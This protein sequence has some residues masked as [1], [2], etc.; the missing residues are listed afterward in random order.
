MDR[1]FEERVPRDGRARNLRR[2]IAS[3]SRA[4]ALIALATTTLATSGALAQGRW[5][6]IGSGTVERILAYDDPETWQELPPFAFGTYPA[7]NLMWLELL[8]LACDRLP[9]PALCDPEVF[10]VAYDASLDAGSCPCSG[11]LLQEI[12]V[13]IHYDADVV[14]ALGARESDLRLVV[15]E[16]SR[17]AWTDMPRGFEVD[18][19]RDV[20]RGWQA[21]HVSQTYAVLAGPPGDSQSWGAIKAHWLR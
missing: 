13:Q 16:A 2:A 3:R 1:T 4:G 15:Y 11:V 10:V 20:V 19:E 9:E 7:G 17:G 12:E 5:I 21:S 8:P 14:R 18:V 6:D